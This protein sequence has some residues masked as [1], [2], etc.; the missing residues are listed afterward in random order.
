MNKEVSMSNA[1]RFIGA[2]NKVDKTLR[3]RYRFKTS[4]NFTDAVR[5]AALVS[6]LVRKYEDELLSY[7]R[8][9]NAIVHNS[10]D[11]QIIAEPNGDVTAHFE[12]IAKLLAAPPK[13]Y[14]FIH[15]AAVIGADKTLRAAVDLM[16]SGDY[17]NVPVVENGTIIGVVTNK[18]IV[19]ALHATP[20]DLDAFMKKTPVG[21]ILENAGRHFAIASADI[22]A[23]AVLKIFADNRK[24]AIL[25]LTENGMSAGKIA[26]VLTVSDLTLLSDAID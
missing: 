12:H 22:T 7:A 4:L 26:G 13:A 6:G 19:R 21:E 20:T 14:K 3:E 23:D 8:L 25:I 5:K 11:T 9:R 17:S 10:D 1:T 24:L 2:Y 16:I 18:M 15:K